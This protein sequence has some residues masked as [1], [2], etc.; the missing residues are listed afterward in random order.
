MMN[1]LGLVRWLKGA[2]PFM[3][4]CK[5]KI[6]NHISISYADENDLN[7]ISL[8]YE[9]FN[10]DNNYV[11]FNDYS[12]DLKNETNIVN[13]RYKLF[14]FTNEIFLLKNK[15]KII[16]VVDVTLPDGK[17]STVAEIISFIIPKENVNETIKYI[18]ERI[19]FNALHKDK[20][21]NTRKTL[22]IKN[23]AKQVGTT[24]SNVYNIIWD[25]TVHV[26]DT[27]LVPFIELFF[28][29]AYNRRTR[30]DKSS[31][32]SKHIKAKSLLISLQTK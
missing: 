23:L 13:L 22:F 8:F 12:K 20:N 1:M 9:T 26:V 15:D 19:K 32:I 16:G 30:K 14:S 28:H 3:N 31:N 17:K 7:D 2:N 10:Y 25:A 4:L 24:A 18:N 11:I 21:C 29:P 6:N 27:N 5:R